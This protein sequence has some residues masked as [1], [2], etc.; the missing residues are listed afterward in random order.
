MT[1]DLNADRPIYAQLMEI[2]EMDIISSRYKPGDKIPPVRELAVL[3][4]VNPNTMQKA[5]SE[6]ERKGLL[7]SHRTSGRYITTDIQM[8]D[9]L[10]ENLALQQINVFLEKMQ[11]LGY[12]NEEIINLV[13][14]N[15]N[16]T[17]K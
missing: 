15:I 9:D 8:I 5:L 2:I 7:H 12:N 6:L 11:G 3:A 4:A 10:K 17:S 16:K 14:F 13:T 1:W